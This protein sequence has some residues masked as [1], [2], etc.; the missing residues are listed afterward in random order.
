MRGD[1]EIF[2]ALEEQDV[3]V[4][5]IEPHLQDVDGFELISKSKKSL[6][7]RKPSFSLK[8]ALCERDC[9]RIQS[10]GD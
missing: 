6:R 3:S 7:T 2:A 8:K 4:M 5:I 10:E 9:K 1:D